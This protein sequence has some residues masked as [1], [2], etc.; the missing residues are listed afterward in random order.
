MKTIEVKGIGDVVIRE[1]D[2]D[3]RELVQNESTTIVQE[4]IMNTNR[5]KQETKVK[6][7]TLNKYTFILG[8]SKAPFFNTEITETGATESIIKQ[9]LLE[10]KKLDYRL[11]ET[12]VPE[13]AEYNNINEDE[14]KNLK[15]NSI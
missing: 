11:I 4:P 13:I 9:R 8:I 7:G 2:N 10:Y 15:K 14:F 12:I 6:I 3:D 5:F 1:F